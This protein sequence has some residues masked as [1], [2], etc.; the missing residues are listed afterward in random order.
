MAFQVITALWMVS[1]IGQVASPPI[2]VRVAIV[3]YEDFHSE[4]AK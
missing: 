3:A 4:V 1:Q 2:N